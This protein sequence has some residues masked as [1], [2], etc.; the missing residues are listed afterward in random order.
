[1]STILLLSLWVIHHVLLRLLARLVLV[2]NLL[3]VVVG[4]L[5][6][7]RAIA[8]AIPVSRCVHGRWRRRGSNREMIGRRAWLNPERRRTIKVF[9]RYGQLE[10]GFGGC[11]P[12]SGVGWDEWWVVVFWLFA[13]SMGAFFLV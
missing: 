12:V 3:L 10:R 11:R 5:G 6:R 2:L 4:G 13:A 7:W 8:R 1:M 9:D